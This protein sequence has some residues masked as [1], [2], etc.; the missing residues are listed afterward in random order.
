MSERL[1]ANSR[2]E[3]NGRERIVKLRPKSGDASACLIVRPSVIRRGCIHLLQ[4]LCHVET[5]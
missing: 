2:R 1:L 5:A 3:S 4:G